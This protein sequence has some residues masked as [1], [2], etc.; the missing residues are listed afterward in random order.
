MIQVKHKGSFSNL[1]RF[2][3]RVS[4]RD[5]LNVL[6]KYGELGVRALSQSTPEDSGTTAS[7]WDYE[8]TNDR[9]STRIAFTNSNSNDGVLIAILLRYGHGTGT[10]GFVQGRD[11]ITPAIQPVFDQLANEVWRE[12]TR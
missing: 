2:F 6:E 7:S 10:G 3:N 5:Y 8:I 1:E 11:F 9:N 12:V 4:R